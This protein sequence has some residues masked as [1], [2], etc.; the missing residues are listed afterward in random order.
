MLFSVDRVSALP[1]RPEL[2]EECLPVGD[3]VLGVP[4]EPRFVEYPF[5]LGSWERIDLP[6]AVAWSIGRRRPRSAS[7]FIR[8]IISFIIEMNTPLCRRSGL[9]FRTDL[10]PASK[11]QTPASLTARIPDGDAP[12]D[13]CSAEMNKAGVTIPNHS[14]AERPPS[15]CVDGDDRTLY[16]LGRCSLLPPSRKRQLPITSRLGGRSGKRTRPAARPA[17]RRRRRPASRRGSPA[18]PRGAR[19]RAARSARR[20]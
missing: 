5:D 4:V 3:R 14:V 6:A 7:V 19:T 9:G 11:Y 18:R 12:S 2:L 16:R 20:R 1:D 15:R 8:N 10:I 13:C 17:P